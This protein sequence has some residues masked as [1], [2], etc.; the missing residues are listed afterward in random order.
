MNAGLTMTRFR[1]WWEGSSLLYG[2]LL[3]GLVLFAT[4]S[5]LVSPHKSAAF[6]EQYHLTAGYSYLRTGDFRLATTHPPLMGMIGATALLSDPALVLPLDDPAWQNGD[7]F[8]FSDRFLWEANSDPQQILVSARR[9]IVLVGLLLLVVLYLWAYQLWGRNGALLV[10]LFA[11]FDPNLLAS[12]RIVTTDLGVSCF[13]ALA[14]WRL[15]R[16]LEAPSLPNLFYTGVAAGLAMSAKYTGL[17]FWP[18]A[19]SGRPSVAA[20]LGARRHWI[21]SLCCSL[22]RLPV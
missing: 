5:L 9:P 22:G 1:S 13:L 17:L 21:D 20:R 12:A 18:A 15:W 16:W 3:L 19:S 14:T 11:V 6:D 10:L 2:A 7:R 8:L 4:Q